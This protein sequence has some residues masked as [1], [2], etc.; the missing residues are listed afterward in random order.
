MNFLRWI[1]RIDNVFKKL[2][3]IINL[4]STLSAFSYPFHLIKKKFWPSKSEIAQKY[5][6]NA[7]HQKNEFFKWLSDDGDMSHVMIYGKP[8]SGKTL[9]SVM[10]ALRKKSSYFSIPLPE[11][12]SHRKIN[13]LSWE[14]INTNHPDFQKLPVYANV[15]FDMVN[16]IS[17][18]HKKPHLGVLKFLESANSNKY[19]IFFNQQLVPR[20]SPFYKGFNWLEKKADELAKVFIKTVRLRGFGDFKIL[21]LE[22]TRDDRKLRKKTF[23]ILVKQEELESF[24][25]RW[26]QGLFERKWDSNHNCTEDHLF[27]W[28]VMNIPPKKG[29]RK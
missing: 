7:L 19:R 8:G 28:C 16:V 9:L 4:I 24:E 26:L 2:Q 5:Y 1:D 14:F 3:P 18:P 6:Q 22:C 17:D 27:P 29:F 20:F 25:T 13:F 23:S 10:I 11:Q 15:F 21:D 12:T